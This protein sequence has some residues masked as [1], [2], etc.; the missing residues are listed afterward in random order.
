MEYSPDQQK[1]ADAIRVWAPSDQQVFVLH[2]PAGSGKTTLAVD[3]IRQIFKD[4]DIALAA[5]TGKAAHVLRTKCVASVAAI[6]TV[7]KIIYKPTGGGSFKLKQLMDRMAN[8]ADSELHL[9]PELQKQ[10]EEEKENDGPSFK[11]NEN[12]IMRSLKVVVLDECSMVYTK[13]GEDMKSF[14]TKILVL[15][16][17]NQLEP[18]KGAGYFNT[19]PD[20]HLTEIHRQAQGSPVLQLATAARTGDVL[21]SVGDC[22]VGRVPKKG[23]GIDYG[24]I[25][26]SCLLRNVDQIL[27]GTHVV[28]RNIN[29]AI[30]ARLG[31]EG[32]L[33][34][35]GEKIICCRNNHKLG[36]LNGQMWTVL[37]VQ[38]LDSSLMELT[39]SGE[40]GSSITCHVLTDL[41]LGRESPWFDRDKGESFD[42]GYAITVHKAQGS[43]WD[44]VVVIDESHKFNQPRKHLYTAITRAA[45]TVTV[46][47]A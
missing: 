10:I 2:G 8:L 38:E 29:Q 11:L 19:D 45:K 39:L 23:G 16:D 28:R 5:F 21:R 27:V 3:V 6:T 47:R 37:G 7:H 31:F 42:Y 9:A 4:A 26:E 30:R 14:G 41:F 44:N 25:A 46:A 12:S 35:I 36:L 40:D 1:A 24:R 15:G 33:P 22:L 18:I 17:P 43:Q 32:P 13:M 20:F 34:N